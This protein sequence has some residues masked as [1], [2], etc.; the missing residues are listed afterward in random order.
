MANNSNRS[1]QLRRRRTAIVRNQALKQ[2]KKQKKASS[3]VNSSNSILVKTGA[4]SKKDASKKSLKHRSISML[5][6]CGIDVSLLG[7]DKDFKSARF[8][9]LKEETGTEILRNLDDNVAR[10]EQYKLL[11]KRRKTLDVKKIALNDAIRQLDDRLGD[12][13]VMMER[14]VNSDH[15]DDFNLLARKIAVINTAPGEEFLKYFRQYEFD[16]DPRDTPMILADTTSI[17]KD[18]EVNYDGISTLTPSEL[19]RGGI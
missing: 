10:E 2:V 19:Y 11:K 16:F 13:R 7:L 1:L 15:R 14:L 4:V 18:L 5:G 9:L 8:S 6:A 3:T 17:V 12:S